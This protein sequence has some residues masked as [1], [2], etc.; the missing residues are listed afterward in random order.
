M[1]KQ[2][3]LGVIG[4]GNISYS[5][6]P[7]YVKD[8]RVK[9][10]AVCEAE[11][12]WLDVRSRELNIDA[13]YTD[14]RDLLANKDVD[15]VSVCLP[16]YLHK[17]VTVAALEA[18]KHVLCEKPMCVNSEEALAMHNAAQK[19][20]KKLMIRQNQRF[21]ADAALL[22]KH[23]EMGTFGDVYLIRTAWRRPMGMMPTPTSQRTNGVIY[24]RNW[25][26]EKDKG[27]G[28]L[29]DL[30]CHLLDFAMYVTGFPKFSEASCSC[31]R[32]FKPDVPDSDKY[33]FDSDDLAIGHL[34]FE[35]GMSIEIETSLGSFVEHEMIFH[36]IYGTKAGAS[37]RGQIKFFGETDGAYTTEIVRQNQMKD[38]DSI[39]AFVDCIAN[40]TESPVPSSQGIEIIRMLDAMYKSAGKIQ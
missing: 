30:G 21:G 13:A 15:A 4:L 23:V 20:G 24:S 34:K 38:K 11:K 36:E 35:N 33:V 14:Y 16:T 3:N 17:E 40:D 27:G 6:I 7:V 19:S 8:E 10:T 22:K 25:F 26:N 1:K 18:G 5:H 31:Y 39:E 37:R 29:R 12:N 9:L 2:I 28:G 32:K